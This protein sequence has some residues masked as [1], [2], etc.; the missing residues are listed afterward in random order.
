MVLCL[1]DQG[2]RHLAALLEG[3][4]CLDGNLVPLIDLLATDRDEFEFLYGAKL[5]E[6]TGSARMWIPLPI[7]DAFQTVE[8]KSINA[9]G[10]W[11]TPDEPEH[12]NKVLF[13]Q[14]GPE[15]GKKAVEIR[16]Q[17]QIDKL[18]E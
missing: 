4:G 5:P 8:I 13:L 6:I 16:Y 15:D 7:T 14:L 3:L 18:Y 10:T 17:R 11:T 2:R 9:P 12:G 1:L